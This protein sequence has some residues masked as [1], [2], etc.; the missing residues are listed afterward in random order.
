MYLLLGTSLTSHILE[1]DAQF[2]AFLIHL[3]LALANIED[4]ATH[5][6]AT[7]ATHEEHP[8]E[9]EEEYGQQTGNDEIQNTIA[10]LVLIVKLSFK[11]ATGASRVNKLLNL[12]VTAIFYR[13]IGFC[14]SL[15]CC[16][17]EYSL[18]A[19]GLHIHFQS[20]GTLVGHDAIGIA[21]VHKV[22]ELA[23]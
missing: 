18:N 8:Q 19:V 5:A 22:L 7:H 1:C 23:I 11:E 15:C 12:G 4:A 9:Y 16:L 14:A 21:V 3:S 6:A 10:A 17:M 20:L 2:A 13:Q